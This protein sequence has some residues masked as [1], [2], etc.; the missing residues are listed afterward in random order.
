MIFTITFVVIASAISLQL[1]Y[2]VPNLHHFRTFPQVLRWQRNKNLTTNIQ[3][4][5]YAQITGMGTGI[6]LNKKKARH[7]FL[8]QVDLCVSPYYMIHSS[9][10][11]R[12]TTQMG[13]K[14]WRKHR[15][16]P[17]KWIELYRNRTALTIRNHFI[18]QLK[19]ATWSGLG[20]N[21]NMKEYTTVAISEAA[22]LNPTD[23][24]LVLWIM[25]QLMKFE[26]NKKYNFKD[27]PERNF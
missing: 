4:R 15:C 11:P 23:V 17:A 5:N 12:M 8:R 22:M 3:P 6:T 20:F 16:K 2:S 27:F 19:V 26:S 25:L 1:F 14:K 13:M 10:L 18:K 24:T 21:A 7:F 9:L